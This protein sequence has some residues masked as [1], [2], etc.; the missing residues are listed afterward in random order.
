MEQRIIELEKKVAFQEQMIEE[1][2]EVLV[3]QQ[4]KISGFERQLNVMTEK[5][6][7]GDFVKKVE[8]EDP[9]PHY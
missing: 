8:E 4:K 1:L 5:I 3:D 9:P 2:N 7:S 6:G